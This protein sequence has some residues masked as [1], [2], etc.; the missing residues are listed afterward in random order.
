MPECIV[1][2]GVA[3]ESAKER[4]HVAEER[5]ERISTGAPSLLTRVES[6]GSLEVSKHLV[7]NDKRISK[8]E[9]IVSTI[10][11]RKEWIFVKM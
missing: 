9:L 7:E 1:V 5:V 11:A 10:E 2:L 8:S 3:T 4:I 6:G